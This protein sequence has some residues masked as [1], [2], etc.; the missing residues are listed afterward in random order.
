MLAILAFDTYAAIVWR[1][2]WD[3]LPYNSNFASYATDVWVCGQRLKVDWCA[4]FVYNGSGWLKSL[5][6]LVQ[7]CVS[8]CR[9]S[10]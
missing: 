8:F 10:A 7:C 9:G 3:L 6:H 1:L 5:P 4:E 2:A